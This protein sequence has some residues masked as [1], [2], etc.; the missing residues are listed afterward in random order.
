M[1]LPPET[2]GGAADPRIQ[3]LK[4]WREA[5]RNSDQLVANA[6]TLNPSARELALTAEL[7][8]EPL[9]GSTTS[10]AIVEGADTTPSKIM[11][12][13][14]LQRKQQPATVRTFPSF[15]AAKAAVEAD[16]KATGST[17]GQWVYRMEPKEAD[18]STFVPEEVQG[19]VHVDGN[20]DVMSV[21]LP[22]MESTAWL[23]RVGHTRQFLLGNTIRPG[24][25]IGTVAALKGAGLGLDPIITRN[26]STIPT[27]SG[28]L[29]STIGYMRGGASRYMWFSH[30]HAMKKVLD[31]AA[32]GTPEGA[33]NASDKAVNL[34]NRAPTKGAALLE[35][36]AAG[37]LLTRIDTLSAAAKELKDA[38]QQLPGAP[39]MDE[40]APRRIKATDQTD[41]MPA[42]WKDALDTPKVKEV[43]DAIQA[44]D[45][46]YFNDPGNVQGS[47]D[48]LLTNLDR[49]D[50][51]GLN[52]AVARGDATPEGRLLQA[53]PDLRQNLLDTASQ[54]ADIRAVHAN[55]VSAYEPLIAKRDGV[56]GATTALDDA[57]GALPG[58][59]TVD[60][61]APGKIRPTADGNFVPDAWKPSVTDP[62]LLQTIAAIDADYPGVFRDASDT[63][64]ALDTLLTRLDRM[65]GATLEDRIARGDATPEGQLLAAFPDLAQNLQDTVETR[66]GIRSA[67]GDLYAA[68]KALDAN[69]A[70]GLL[71]SA[72]SP[73]TT[74]GNVVRKTTMGLSTLTGLNWLTTRMYIDAPGAGMFD[75]LSFGSAVVA[76]KYSK[77]NDALAKFNAKYSADDI[78]ADPKLQELKAKYSN[79]KDK[80]NMI[81]DAAGSLGAFRS[82]AAAANYYASGFPVLG[83]LSM[84]QGV[85]TMG[86]VAVQRPHWAG[87]AVSGAVRVGTLGRVR[88]DPQMFTPAGGPKWATMSQPL[89]TT[90][91]MGAITSLVAVPSVVFAMKYVPGVNGD[92]EANKGRRKQ[93]DSPVEWTWDHTLGW[94]FSDHG[95][96]APSPGTST[97]P[98]SGTSATPSPTA[99]ATSSATPGATTT[100]SPTAVP[101]ATQGTGTPPGGTPPTTSPSNP[102]TTPPTTQAP[103]YFVVDDTIGGGTFFGISLTAVKQGYLLTQNELDA[104]RSGTNGGP[105][106][107]KGVR[108]AA[109]DRLFS[110]NPRYLPA[111]ADGVVTRDRRD[112]DLLISGDRIDVGPQLRSVG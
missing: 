76:Y 9:P 2:V 66:A 82:F 99:T 42:A 38:L 73:L 112:P 96:N 4:S 1:P 15:A 11:Y 85:L 17:A 39:H 88:P 64:G 111:L 105:G 89:K 22:N 19:A 36:S 49:M 100:A 31:L 47:L 98:S 40:F 29:P 60:A 107:Y 18:P 14:A 53:F 13:D 94:V 75:S 28:P 12:G 16:A 63:G 55:L 6:D 23:N 81:G 86:W 5:A 8:A 67:H 44:D 27:V 84:A 102:P 46:G 48:T 30:A 80:W 87:A 7:L 69:Q 101:T 57:L 68:S 54:R 50:E 37:N 51:A 70:E 108:R 25:V 74:L 72:N 71:G 10:F 24:V 34:I 90:L 109:I 104:A 35:P 92:Y 45:P 97:T 56:D 26:S 33:K 110:L 20:G 79:D 59:P 3:N 93:G 78:A 95:G 32:E 77:A 91:R 103:T 106:G 43:V 21:G 58:A 61:F 83:H 65:D 62:R 52:D 41:F